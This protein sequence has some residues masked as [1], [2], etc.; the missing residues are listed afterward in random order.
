MRQ[1]DTHLCDRADRTA[2]A[3]PPVD[4]MDE[5]RCFRCSA[6]RDWIYDP[7]RVSWRK[8]G[9]FKSLH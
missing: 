8:L 7:H 5:P 6:V 2:G 9:S 1:V 4:A 3:G